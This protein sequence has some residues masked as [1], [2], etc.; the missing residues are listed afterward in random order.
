MLPA[1]AFPLD[2][3][4]IIKYFP[5]CRFMTYKQFAEINHC[6]IDDVIRL[7]E[8]KSGC[9][10]YDVLQNRYLI[11]CNQSEANNNGGRKRWT[12]G[13]ELGH[14]ICKH[15]AISAYT[16]LS[17][18]NIVRQSDPEYE[19]EADYFAATLLAPFPLFD[20]LNIHSPIDVQLRF[21]LSCEASIY[22]Y[23]QYIK[24]KQT[25]TKTAWENDLLHT[26]IQKSNICIASRA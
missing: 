6:T 23:K 10:H 2:V 22:R 15:H 3:Q 11:L 20:I 1:I 14:V 16:K 24:W 12:E 7:C 4:N 9:T 13:H 25:K 8:S 17:E 19:A 21:G 18:N 26:Y 5:E